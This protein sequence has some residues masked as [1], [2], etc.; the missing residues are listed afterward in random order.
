[1]IQW[2][3]TLTGNQISV[4]KALKHRKFG[5]PFDMG[6][7]ISHWISGIR[8]LIK[9]GLIEHRETRKPNSQYN[10]STRTG[11]FLTERGRFI[12]QMIEQDVEKFLS[13][14]NEDVPQKKR[15][16]KAA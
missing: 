14:K 6:D 1:M 9:E 8:P 11:Q 16:R 2:S 10:D 12:L 13:A 7:G 5:E 15:P 4:L 3:L